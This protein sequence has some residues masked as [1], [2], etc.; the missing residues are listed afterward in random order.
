MQHMLASLVAP[1]SKAAARAIKCSL[2]LDTAV[3]HLTEPTVPLLTSIRTG[4]MAESN[5]QAMWA[6]PYED[7][8]AHSATKTL[9]CHDR[10]NVLYR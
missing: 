3:L 2:R 1:T 9:Q 8:H 5:W 10:S 7:Q 4:V 6:R